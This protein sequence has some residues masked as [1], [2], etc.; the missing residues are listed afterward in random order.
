MKKIVVLGSSGSIGTQ[1]LDIACNLAS[2]ICIKGLA[3]DSNI[4]ILKLQIKKFKPSAVSVNNFIESRNLEKWCVSNNIE[5]SVYSGPSG[6]ERLVEMPDVDMVLVAIVGAAGLKSTIAA[7]K[8]KKDIA[9]AN[10]ETLV[11]AG[12]Y[13]MGLAAE[14]GVSILPIDSEHSAIF[15]CCIREK[16][17]QIKKIVLTASGGPF[18]KYDKEFSKITIEEALNH[19]TWKM[20]RKITVDSATLM[21]KGLEVIEASVLFGIPIEKI[22]IIMHPQSILHSMVE[23]ID[24]SVI[25]QLSNPDMKLPIQYALTYPERLPS[26]IKSLNF[27]DIGK[28][29]FFKPDFNK[30]PCLKLSYYA[31]KKGFT[32]PSVMS[33]ANE[34]AVEAFLNKEIKFTNIAEIVEKTMYAHTISKS[35]SLDSFIEADFWAR[36]Y[37]R[38]L[39]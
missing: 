1:A 30:F 13:I 8:S 39:I 17:S 6:F 36:H 19:P 23:Y 22:E 14:K 16:K 10:K 21:N 28:L 38:K 5:V 34:V 35:L 7:I 32:M 11:M 15:Q 29:E 4:E 27:V 33:A 12:S 9:I 2:D 31:A 26:N 3:V 18:Y 24:G 37:A 25:A 20:G